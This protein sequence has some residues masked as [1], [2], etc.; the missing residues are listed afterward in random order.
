MQSMAITARGPAKYFDEI[1]AVD[2]LSLDIPR[3]CIVA[4]LGGNGAG[5]TNAI[6]M[7]PR[8]LIPSA[9]K[10][11]VL[12]E[13]MLRHRCRV[14]PRI[15]F[16][17]SS[18]DFPKRPTPRENLNVYAELCG[19][20]KLRNRIARIARELSIDKFMDRPTGQLSSGQKTRVAHAK[21]LF[22]EP[23]LPLDEPTASPDPETASPL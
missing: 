18:V 17:P 7:I 13:D 14:L 16:F 21:S 8:L 1:T 10:I 3:N 22:N 4:L 15:I 12:G 2:G 9:G 20:D 11:T 23:E 6:S 5:K 19:V